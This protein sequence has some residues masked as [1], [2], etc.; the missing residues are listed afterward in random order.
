MKDLFVSIRGRVNVNVEALNMVE[1]VGNYVKHRR[2]P[3]VY[4]KDGE[5]LS[6]YVPAISG[7]SIAHGYQETLSKTA[8]EMDL[9]V[10]K[11]CR[12]GIFLKST[13]SQ[14][15]K[16]SMEAEKVPK[17]DSILEESIIKGCVVE[18]VGGFLFA[19]GGRS[20]KR[21]SSFYVG[22][23]IPVREAIEASILESQLHTRN[24]IGTEF[25]KKEG[26]QMIYYVEIASAVYGFSLDLDTT[27]IGR[28]TSS[29]TKAGE[30]AVSEE[31]AL[32]R[33][34]AALLALKDFLLE[35]SFGAK[36]TRFLPLHEWESIVIAVSDKT[37]TVPSPL[38]KTYIQRAMEKKNAVNR[39][40]ELFI[41]N[42]EDGGSF[43]ETVNTTINKALERL[44]Q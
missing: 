16:A 31:E 12:R 42:S 44:A 25:V 29:P 15:Y 2:V 33:K 11:L 39:G 20:V 23:M 10:C 26:G 18:D 41:Y 1:S 22:Y 38:V 32:N 43:E 19:E 13:N 35:M 30:L 28:L 8:L 24:A 5:Y 6:L 7:E 9:P 3:V 36:K 17:D 14:I 4:Y 34:K 37:W 21:T 40:T 27:Y